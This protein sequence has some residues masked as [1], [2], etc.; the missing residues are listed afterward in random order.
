MDE[1]GINE[2]ENHLAAI[3]SWGSIT[4]ALAKSPLSREQTMAIREECAKLFFDPLLLPRLDKEE[5][6]VHNSLADES[7]FEIFTAILSKDREAVYNDYAFNLRPSTDNQP[8]WLGRTPGLKRA[9]STDQGIFSP[10]MGE[11]EP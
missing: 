8:F 10:G 4:F 11:I 6:Q 9:V 2:P 5:R 1:L 3:R 7:F